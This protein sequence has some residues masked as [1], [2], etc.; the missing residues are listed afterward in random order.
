[1]DRVITRLDRRSASRPAPPP[2]ATI[3]EEN[4]PGHHPGVEQAMPPVSR[5]PN[6]PAE[7]FPFAFEPY[8]LLL[9]LPFGITPFTSGVTVGSTDL[10]IRYGPWS[11]HTSLDNVAGAETTGPYTFIKTAGPPH[12]S[13]VDRGISFVT[14]RSPGVC[15]RFREPV[16]GILPMHSG[17]IRHPGATVTVSWPDELIRLLTERR[18]GRG[19]ARGV[20]LNR[21]A[22]RARRSARAGG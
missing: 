8:Q 5:L 12:L 19:R 14:R 20:P 13:L 11:L 4:L 1:M 22:R 10:H 9:G 21:A 17:L 6:G 16:P 2:A 15:V 3:P 7:H 18:V